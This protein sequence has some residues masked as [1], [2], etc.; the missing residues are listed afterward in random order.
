MAEM[1][2]WVL[3]GKK[4]TGR[5]PKP[6]IFKVD[7]ERPPKKVIESFLK[8]RD[9]TSTVSDVLDTMGLTSQVVSCTILKPSL[10]TEIVGPA[11]TLRNVPT[12][13]TPKTAPSKMAEYELWNFAEP[14]DVGVLDG[15][16]FDISNMGGL[17]ARTAKKQGVA[18]AV[19][20]GSRRDVE[21]QKEL[22]FPI[23][24][25]GESPV[26]GKWRLESVSMNAPIRIV[27]V[28]VE[29]GDLVIADSTGVCFVPRGI[30]ELV[31]ERT[32]E[33]EKSE[34]EKRKK[35]QG[36]VPISEHASVLH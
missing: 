7:I 10:E 30:I 11:I 21:E 19:I 15:G 1:S 5:I 33:I 17:S 23:W 14:G 18:G 26:T 29:P 22:E 9:L 2:E 24:S 13:T 35:I 16:G 12:P 20:D 4:L 27:N 8:I 3:R 36:G 34:D 28:P 25:R 31:L 6:R 32:E